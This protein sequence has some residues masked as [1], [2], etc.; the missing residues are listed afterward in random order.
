MN[1]IDQF[2][3][4]DDLILSRTTPPIQAELRNQLALMREQIEAYH[5]ASDKQDQTLSTQAEAT[6]NE[7]TEVHNPN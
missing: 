1:M 6:W 4:L 3:K 7:I 2:Q 5:A